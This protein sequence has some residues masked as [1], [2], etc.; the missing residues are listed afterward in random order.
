MTFT[1]EQKVVV[2]LLV[3]TILGSLSI[4]SYLQEQNRKNHRYTLINEG[5]EF[6]PMPPVAEGMNTED[7]S[8]KREISERIAIHIEG[9]VKN[10]GLYYLEDNSRYDDAVTLAGGLIEGADRSKVNLAKKIYD[11]A[12]IYIPMIGEDWEPDIE[13]SS[14]NRP[15]HHDENPE[16]RLININ[17]AT[18]QELMSLSGIGEV[19]AQR[20]VDYRTA[21]G[22]FQSLEDLKN[23]S[24][25]GNVTF[26]NI[27]AQI[28]K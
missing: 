12:F 10:P 1:K 27:K 18:Q 11:E 26:N 7:Q 25:I 8:G 2:I 23:V 3:L 4:I 6:F 13:P 16:Q 5:E 9:A 17:T 19:Y 21:N 28:T 20:I 15:G 22:D 24:G 14:G